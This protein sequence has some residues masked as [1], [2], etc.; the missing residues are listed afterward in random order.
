MLTQDRGGPVDVTTR[1][2]ATL[3]EQGHEAV[4]FG[5]APARGAELVR[6]AHVPL[7]VGH[8]GD[9]RAARAARAALRDF[10]PDVVH[11]QD[12]RAGLVAAGLRAAPVVHTY[13]GVPE[14]VSQEWFAGRAGAAAPSRYTRTVLAAD[15]ALARAVTRTVVPADAMGRFLRERLRVPARRIEHID[16]GVLTGKPGPVVHRVRRLLFVGLMVPRKGVLTLLE[17]I[18]R[19]GVLPPGAVLD[20][21]GDGPTLS[22]ARA[23][24][25]G[26]G[27]TVRDRVRFLGFR[28]DVPDLVRAYDA[29]VLP[30][31]MEQQPVALAE[32]MAAGRPVVAT[33]VGG[34][35]EMLD[36]PGAGGF[37]VPP[38]D[39]AALGAALGRLFAAGDLA[40]YG[41][42]LRARAVQRYSA[43]ACADAHLGLY[44]R[45]SSTVPV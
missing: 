42:D 11:A 24:L 35:R 14:D 8:K 29:L 6:G 20:I 4:L 27:A 30:S 45:L 36:V 21:A 15:A 41:A 28:T 5:P 43:R 18:A 38:G 3:R 26:P 44:Q 9:L 39:P 40:D 23:Y 22:D 31:E 19:P 7:A 25:A 32:A 12:R 2:L 33:D 10:A 1:L 37:V 34:V 13:H 17:A 16:N